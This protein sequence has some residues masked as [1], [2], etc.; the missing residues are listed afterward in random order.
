MWTEPH[1]WLLRG[2][3][4]GP[5]VPARHDGSARDRSRR[6]AVR[7]LPRGWRA[8]TAI[9]GGRPVDPSAL[10]R[11]A[12]RGGRAAGAAGRAARR[13][14]SGGRRPDLRCAAGRSPDGG[15]AHLVPRRPAGRAHPPV[16]SFRAL[17]GPGRSGRPHRTPAG[18]GGGSRGPVGAV[19]SRRQRGSPSRPGG[20]HP[21]GSGSP[22]AAGRRRPGRR[23]RDAEI[24]RRG[25]GRDVCG[26]A[27]RGVPRHR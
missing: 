26:A 23:V 10:A 12:A 20:V 25:D 11:R 14:R 1:G 9:T 13:S 22:A 19:R 16:R 6:P 15:R 21:G 3:A 27:G 17:L 18:D 5:A 8:D 2:V 24:G 7:R 4:S